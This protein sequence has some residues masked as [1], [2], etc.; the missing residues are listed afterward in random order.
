MVPLTSVVNLEHIVGPYAI[1]RY[2]LYPAVTINGTAAKNVS[3]GQAMAEM[4]K[5]SDKLLP[6]GMGYSWSGTSLQEK[7]SYLKSEIIELTSTNLHAKPYAYCERIRSYVA[8]SE[9]VVQGN[10]A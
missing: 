7:Q 4:E 10:L 1:T 5:L 9:H 8:V 2:N 6:E 3:S